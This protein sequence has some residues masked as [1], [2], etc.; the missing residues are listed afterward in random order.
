VPA[1]ASRGADRHCRF[2]FAR[3]VAST[4]RE[5]LEVKLQVKLFATLSRYANGL[6]A[7]T[8]F[9]VELPEGATLQDLVINL[10]IPSEETRVIFVNGVIQSLD[11]TLNPGDSIGLFPPIAGG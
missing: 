8:P 1:R 7:G 10:K 9:E 3:R 11:W 4:A 2:K 6:P 5:E